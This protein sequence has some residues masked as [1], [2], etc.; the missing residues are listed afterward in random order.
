MSVYFGTAIQPTG[1]K[2][3]LYGNFISAERQ[4]LILVRSNR[5][6][7]CEYNDKCIKV[8]HEV[9]A[10]GKIVGCVKVKLNANDSKDCVAFLTTKLQLVIYSFDENGNAE[11]RVMGTIEKG[12]GNDSNTGVLMVAL[13][14]NAIVVHCKSSSIEYVTWEQSADTKKMVFVTKQYRRYAFIAGIAALD[15]EG[16]YLGES[17]FG[18]L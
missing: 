8:I 1:I 13:K 11:I 16:M 12:I 2:S 7:L 5:L 18:L 17:Y 3:I 14:K 6:D 15:T 10:K 4:N 9:S